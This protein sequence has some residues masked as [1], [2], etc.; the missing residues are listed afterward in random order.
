[1]GYLIQHFVTKNTKLITKNDA[2]ALERNC[3]AI[4][5]SSKKIYFYCR[6][7]KIVKFLLQETS[8][9]VTVRSKLNLHD[10]FNRS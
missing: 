4:I 5:L 2:S 8:I 3:Y 10:Y 1:M 6:P 7:I 9:G